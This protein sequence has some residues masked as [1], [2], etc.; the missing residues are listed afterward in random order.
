VYECERPRR[1]VAQLDREIDELDQELHTITTQLLPELLAECGV[2]PIC[3]DQLVVSSGDPTRMTSEASFA[4]L[5]G[6]SP[7]Q[8]SSGLQQRH[9][10]NR[11][12]DRQLNRA[13]H[14][15]ALHRV[16]WHPQ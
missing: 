10:L 14:V 3:A 6:T 2:G 7:V 4:A 13:L 1:R 8:A 9:R 12:G 5:A 16:R 15:I 11:G